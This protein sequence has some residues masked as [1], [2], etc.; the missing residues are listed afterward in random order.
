[1][2]SKPAIF[3][4]LIALWISP[5]PAGGQDWN[6]W[7]GASRN[8]LVSHFSAPVRWPKSLTQKWK[9][10]IGG[11]YSSPVVAGNRVYVHTRRDEQEV[12]SCVDLA[13]G[14][15]LWSQT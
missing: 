8:A 14:K 11:S 3:P 10:A 9:V 5:V 2:K 4:L 15:L 13:N 12:V 1:M 6:Q 7:R